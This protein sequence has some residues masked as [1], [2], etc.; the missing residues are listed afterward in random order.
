MK[1]NVLIT[2]ATSGIGYELAKIFAENKYNLIISARNKNMMESIKIDFEKKYGINV[3]IFEKDLSQKNSAA[4]LFNEVKSKNIQV[5]ILINNAGAGYVG[6]FLKEDLEKDESIMELN[7]DSL[8]ILTKLFA[9]EMVKRRSGKILNVASTGAYHPGPY[10]AVYYA[11][12]AYVLSFTEALAVELKP[13]N[14]KV[15]ALCPGATKTNFSKNAGKKDNPT[16]MK[17]SYVAKKAYKGLMKNKTTII[18][19]LQYKVFVM[20]PR[21]LVTPLIGKYQNI[22]KKN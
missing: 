15:S 11:T 4:E 13:Y 20:L 17:P 19:G 3:S 7:M 1:E 22:L 16:A 21:K 10:T 14:I 9:K 6:E 12:K 18:P 8:T 5:D 2:G